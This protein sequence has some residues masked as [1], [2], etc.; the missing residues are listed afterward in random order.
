MK[1]N[2]TLF[3]VETM[4]IETILLDCDVNRP[5]VSSQLNVDTTSSTKF[6]NYKFNGIIIEVEDV[7]QVLEGSNWRCSND[8]INVRVHGSFFS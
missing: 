2:I 1:L 6:N 3:D 5:S 8:I 4:R 7:H